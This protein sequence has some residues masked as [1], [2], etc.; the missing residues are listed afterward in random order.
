MNCL[1]K[2]GWGKQPCDL[3]DSG[4]LNRSPISREIDHSLEKK[5]P[6]K[7]EATKSLDARSVSFEPT[8]Q[9]RSSREKTTNQP[10]II[11]ANGLG[12]PFPKPCPQGVT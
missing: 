4:A 8:N 2:G 10:K 3:E 11:L 12:G 7:L 5:L 1:K 6:K 9:H